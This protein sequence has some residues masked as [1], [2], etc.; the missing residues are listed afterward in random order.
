MK[1]LAPRVAD[2]VQRTHAGQRGTG[3]LAANDT[4]P[5]TLLPILKRQMREQMTPLA[6]TAGLFGTWAKGAAKG[7]FVPR[8]LGQVEIEVEDHSGPAAARTFPLFRLQDVLDAYAAMDDAARAR[9][10][11]L[12]D[13]IGGVPLKTFALPARLVR[14][15]YRLA[16]G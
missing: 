15:N 14:S 10:D 13:E 2:Y 5:E 7:D 16:L 6:E 1:R 8:A 3:D 4:I 9:A 11:E 12:L